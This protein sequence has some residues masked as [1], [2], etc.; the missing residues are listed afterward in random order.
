MTKKILFLFIISIHLILSGCC[1]ESFD[2]LYFS[3]EDIRIT[4]TYRFREIG[5]GTIINQEGFK[6]KC[7]FSDHIIEAISDIN[8][9]R[10]SLDYCEDNLIALKE[11]IASLKIT[12]NKNIWN[13]PAGYPLDNN[14]IS[15]IQNPN[16]SIDIMSFSNDEW[17]EII[18][19]EEKFT[20]FEWFIEFNEE[21]S[22]NEYLKFEL[23]FELANGNMYGIETELVK[24]E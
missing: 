19:A 2:D 24:F 18:N 10:A 17:V 5:D 6:I 9:L 12:C 8:E 20:S 21:I 7:Y 3:L 23:L 22:S 16:D 15:F 13:T 1:K 11:D 14:K 4:N